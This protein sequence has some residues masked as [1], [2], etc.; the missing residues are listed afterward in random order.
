LLIALTVSD[1]H[2]R[3]GRGPWQIAR[4]LF[5]PFALVGIYLLLITL[6]L[7]RGGFA[8][9]LSIASAVV[10]FQLIILSVS[11]AMSALTTRRPII[12]NMAFDRT[13]IPVSSVLTES[14][15]FASSFI[16]IALMM[17]IYGVTPTVALVWLPFAVAATIVLAVGIAYPASLFGIWFREFRPFGLSFVRMLF[18]AGPGLVGLSQIHGRT[19]DLVRL[20]PLAGI[21]E[22]YRD[23]FLY[24][25]SPAAWELLYP[26]GFG[27]FLLAL[28]VP[29]YRREQP[30][31]A[32]VVE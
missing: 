25:K 24:G 21:F 20:N 23:I 11:N 28:F 6:V 9:G 17:A 32:K 4:W 27:I 15:A 8:P 16:L 12:L 19:A 3:Y 13:L 10:P 22:S 7:R 14:A 2:V 31:F 18:F 30:H 26:V 1:L 29:L 5:D